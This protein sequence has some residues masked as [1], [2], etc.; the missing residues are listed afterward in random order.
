MSDFTDTI[1][2]WWEKAHPT[3]LTK[4]SRED[5]YGMVSELRTTPFSARI[6]KIR[7]MTDHNTVIQ[8]ELAVEVSGLD[9]QAAGKFLRLLKLVKSHE[10]FKAKAP[11]RFRSV[12][13]QVTTMVDLFSQDVEVEAIRQA[14]IP[15]RERFLSSAEQAGYL[16]LQAIEDERKLVL[17][18]YEAAEREL[19]E[20]LRQ[21]R[22]ER[23]EFGRQMSALIP[24]WRDIKAARDSS[25]TNQERTSLVSRWESAPELRER[26]TIEAYLAAARANK[27]QL[28]EK[29]VYE[30]FL[31]VGSENDCRER[32]RS[33]KSRA[34][35]K[36]SPV[37]GGAG[38]GGPPPIDNIA[39]P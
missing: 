24:P 30:S 3:F 13:D 36:H 15:R 28:S 22:V 34:L 18:E 5:F 21:L 33:A 23:D 27:S 16:N 38:G 19:A 11:E 4:L 26:Y 7:V 20:K 17:R 39:P 6:D 10:D 37:E 9:K 12:F 25:L 2:P 8:F 14:L 29:K 32:V 35:A 31:G 1:A